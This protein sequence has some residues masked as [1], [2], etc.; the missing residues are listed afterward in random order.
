VAYLLA[1]CLLLPITLLVAAQACGLFS[2]LTQ[3]R[4]DL[5]FLFQFPS[6]QRTTNA[7]LWW[8]LFLSMPAYLWLRRFTRSSVFSLVLAVAVALL[9]GVTLL[10]MGLLE[11]LEKDPGRVYLRLAP[12]AALFFAAAAMLERLRFPSDSRYFYPI[13]VAFTYVSL[14]GI[15]AFHEPYAKWLGRVAPW[16]RGQVEYLF[17]VN[18]GAYF[19]M[20]LLCD[21]PRLAQMRAAAKAFRFV[22]P[23]HL[24]IPLFLL[25]LEATRLWEESPASHGLRRE[26]RTLEV[27]LPAVAGLFVL[28]SIPRQMKNYLGTGMFFLAVGIIRLQQNWLKDRVAWPVTLILAGILLMIWAARYSAVRSAIVRLFGR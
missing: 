19:L 22:L 3:G 28:L 13:A 16:T 24:L 18:A 25:G 20:Q 5:E 11:W 10:R 8:S 27:L 15:A 2:G 7:Q 17:I 12:A 26:A 9:C 21:R 4:E 1:A 6:F 23:G 14:S